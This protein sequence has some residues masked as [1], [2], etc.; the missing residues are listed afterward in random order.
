MENVLLPG[1]K[2]NLEGSCKLSR[3]VSLAFGHPICQSHCLH[4]HVLLHGWQKTFQLSNNHHLCHT[5]CAQAINFSISCRFDYF[6]LNERNQQRNLGP[7]LKQRVLELQFA[8]LQHSFCN[9]GIV[10]SYA[11]DLQTAGSTGRPG[12]N[13]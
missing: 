5:F 10:V 13:A 1:L 6:T 7:C 8:H 3:A 4:C 11:C 9:S 12:S 2:L